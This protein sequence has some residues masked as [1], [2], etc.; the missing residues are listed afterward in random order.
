MNDIREKLDEIRESQIRMEADLKYHIMR[1]DL[2]EEK[3]SKTETKMETAVEELDTRLHVVEQPVSFMK[4]V[5]I[6]GGVLGVLTG[7]TA[8]YAKFIGF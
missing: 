4:V 5:K 1:T 8:L 3:L 2:L 7:L 6:I